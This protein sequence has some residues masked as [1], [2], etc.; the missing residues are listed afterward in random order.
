MFLCT[1]DERQLAAE[2]LNDLIVQSAER[3]PSGNT[4]MV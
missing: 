1:A 2:E 4:R 3:T